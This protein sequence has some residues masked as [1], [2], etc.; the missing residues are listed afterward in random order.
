MMRATSA[1]SSRGDQWELTAEEV[2]MIKQMEEDERR[3]RDDIAAIEFQRFQDGQDSEVRHRGEAYEQ[4]KEAKKYRDWEDWE[5]QDAMNNPVA[6]RPGVRVRL[7]GRVD[8]GTSQS[9]EWTVASGQTVHL[10]L[11]I[12]PGNATCT[13]EVAQ[14]PE[15]SADCF[16]SMAGT[17]GDDSRDSTLPDVNLRKRGRADDATAEDAPTDNET[18]AVTVEERD[19]TGL[20]H[21]DEVLKGREGTGSKGWRQVTAGSATVVLEDSQL[22]D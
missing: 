19:D 3:S 17:C 1:A 8:N 11:C 6:P 7:T 20:L 13:T 22:P 14:L 21:D 10:A 16:P 12:G 2:A 15:G 4:E 5:V 18:S 9:M